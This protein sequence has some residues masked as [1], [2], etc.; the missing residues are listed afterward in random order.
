VVKKITQTMS[1][2]SLNPYCTITAGHSKM[3]LGVGSGENDVGFGRVLGASHV[4]VATNGAL[5]ILSENLS[6]LVRHVVNIRFRA[7][8]GSTEIPKSFHK[9]QKS[10]VFLMKSHYAKH[11]AH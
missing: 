4:N 5:H 1:S 9:M 7:A 3:Q 11:A 2:L 8:Y 6:K 10:Q